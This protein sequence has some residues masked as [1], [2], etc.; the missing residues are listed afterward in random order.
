MDAVRERIWLK[1]ICEELKLNGE[2]V[3]VHCDSQSVIYLAKNFVY[4]EK[5]KHIATEYNFIKYIVADE[6]VE[7]IMIHTSVNP[8]DMLIK[9]LPEEKFEGCLVKLRIVKPKEARSESSLELRRRL[10]VGKS[11][12]QMS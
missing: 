4:R 9:T 5:T 3:E 7:V 11:L 8:T 12:R 6:V 10:R 2:A 1:G